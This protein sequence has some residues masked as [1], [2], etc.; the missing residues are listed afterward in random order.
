MRK[1]AGAHQKREKQNKKRRRGR[2]LGHQ[3][4]SS[5]SSPTRDST[6]KIMN[7]DREWK[8]GGGNQHTARHNIFIYFFRKFFLFSISSPSSGV[9]CVQCLAR[10]TIGERAGTCARAESIAHLDRC[11]VALAPAVNTHK[12]RLSKPPQSSSSSLSIHTY[13]KKQDKFFFVFV[14]VVV[15]TFGCFISIHPSHRG[16]IFKKKG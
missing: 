6:G 3:N 7:A 13:R 14:E 8:R 1:K 15:Q 2:L 4:S 9:C 16:A 5:F 11:S 10:P 12:S